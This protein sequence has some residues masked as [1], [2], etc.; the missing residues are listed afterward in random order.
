MTCFY[1]TLGIASNFGNNFKFQL[2]HNLQAHLHSVSCPL[3]PDYRP[4]SVIT[5]IVYNIVYC[6]FLMVLL[7]SWIAV[8]WQPLMARKKSFMHLKDQTI[9]A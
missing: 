2:F 4:Y 1:S 5:D 8:C 9:H 6:I 3:F 7:A